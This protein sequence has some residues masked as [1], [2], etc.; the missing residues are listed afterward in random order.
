MSSGSTLSRRVLKAISIFGTVQ[1]I[2]MLCS[3]IRVK[4]VALWMG[5]SGIGL[6]GMLNQAVEMLTQISQ[7]N[8]RES[9]VRAIVMNPVSRDFIS[10][11]VSR[12]SIYLGLVGAL[13]TLSLA[14]VLG[15]LTFGE[16]GHSGVF[17]ALSVVVFLRVLIAGRQS[18]LQAH[19]K[20]K[21]L[22]SATLWGNLAGTGIS[23]VLFRLFGLDSI[24]P[25]IIVFAV[26]TWMSYR[27]GI[28]EYSPTRITL[29]TVIA[30]SKPIVTLGVYMTIAAFIS[31]LSTYLFLVWLRNYEDEES[32]G[33]YQAG[34]TIISQYVGLVFVAISLEF[35]PRVAAVIN[36][37]FP[38]SV[39]V[40]HEIIL[41]ECLLVG[42]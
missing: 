4:C 32:V 23:I 38:T 17:L 28:K 39:Y 34:F 14:P 33:Y 22:A 25:A 29:N 37:R 42:C 9:G 12:L 6:F 18:I 30:E 41:L 13:L 36:S 10:S 26:V 15:R 3:V 19:R 35:Y 20:L 11:I 7:L 1:M 2:T 21:R 27:M 31:S 24:V 40:R 5:A 8:I 16:P